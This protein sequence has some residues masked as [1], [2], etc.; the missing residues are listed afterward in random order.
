MKVLYNYVIWT[1]TCGNMPTYTIGLLVAAVV[2]RAYMAVS[3]LPY[4]FMQC[5]HVFR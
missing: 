4:F 5:I 2:L 3:A 1:F